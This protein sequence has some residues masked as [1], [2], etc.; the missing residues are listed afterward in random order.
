MQCL[1]L[2]LV[3]EMSASQNSYAKYI[4]FYRI[5][6]LDL[7]FIIF[8]AVHNCGNNTHWCLRLIS[9]KDASTSKVPT[10]TSDPQVFTASSSTEV[11]GETSDLYINNTSDNLPQTLT[12]TKRS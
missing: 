11:L 6:I 3:D 8:H 1:K 2:A 9:Y 10:D 4:S 12:Q 5:Q 7:L